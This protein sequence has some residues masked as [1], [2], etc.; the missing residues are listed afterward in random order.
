MIKIFK[1]VR[2]HLIDTGKTGRYLKYAIGEIIL[3]VIGILIALQINKWNEFRKSEDIK[4]NYYT[5]ILQDLAKD[6]KFLKSQIATLNDNI[7]LYST[8]VETFSNHKNP[9]TL[10]LSASKLNYSYDYLKFDTNTIETLQTT[11]D[12]KLLPSEIR[13][14]LIDLKNMQNNIITQSYS[15]NTNFLK[16]FLSAV[17]LGYH[18][19][20]LALKN[21]NASTNELF[22]SLNISDNFPEIA[23][24]LNAAFSLKDFTERDLLKVFRMLV[25]NINTLFTLINKELGNPYQ[26]I[27]T[28]LSKLKKLET[29]LEDGKTVD[30]I[31]AVVKNQDIES[32]E[33]DISEAY[34]NAL[35]YFVMNNMKQNKEALKLFKLNIELYPNAYN[36]YDSYGECLMLMGD[37]KNAIKAYKKSL[38]L[39]PEN[40][41][42][43]NALLELE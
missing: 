42:A 24:T 23:L 36:T 41:S 17:K 20:T 29:L 43:I 13:N 35:A 11:G 28:V 40:Q 22:T 16:E 31:I 30:Q 25:A 37:R 21:E 9:E 6:H 26:S 32:P 38:E 10:I 14:K 7:T 4:N 27:E 15:N 19:N 12:I 33:Y 18:P 2:Y 34:I 8:F 39:N 5:Q 3:V 1:K